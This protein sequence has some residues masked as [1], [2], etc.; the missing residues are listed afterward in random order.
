MYFKI[1]FGYPADRFTVKSTKIKKI[2]HQMKGAVAFY[3]VMFL[4][5]ITEKILK[6][7]I[8]C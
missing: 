4:S 8:L 7:K 6:G 2:L 1:T 3:S 5:L